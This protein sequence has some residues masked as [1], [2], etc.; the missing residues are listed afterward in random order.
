[1]ITAQALSNHPETPLHSDSLGERTAVPDPRTGELV[2]LLRVRPALTVIPS[3]EFALRERLA[4]LAN[5]RHPSFAV[6]RRVDRVPAPGLGIIVVSDHIAGTRLSELL[7]IAR[8]QRLDVD[9]STA[10]CLLRQIVPSIASLH[11]HVRGVAHGLVAPDRLVITPQ[12]RV[13]VVEHVFGAAIGQLQLS[14]KGLWDEFRATVPVDCEV[15]RFDPRADILSLGVVA[16][17]LVLG[18]PIAG[19]EFPAAL[20]A[21]LDQARERTALGYERPLSA[22]LR[23]WIERALQIHGS[24]SFATAAEAAGALEAIVADDSLYVTA[25]ISLEMFLARCAAAAIRPAMPLG[26]LRAT[27]PPRPAEAPVV[28]V[29]PAPPPAVERVQPEPIL[30][31][32]IAPDIT[33][34]MPPVAAAARMADE[35]AVP[36]ADDIDWDSVVG[37]QLTAVATSQDITSLFGEA[38]SLLE[39]AD[40]T[41]GD[42]LEAIPDRAEPPSILPHLPSMADSVR[43]LGAVSD[44]SALGSRLSS[45]RSSLSTLKA[46]GS[47][48]AT[49]VSSRHSAL[50]VRASA[51]GS[52]VDWSAVSRRFGIAALLVLIVGGGVIVARSLLTGVSADAS[53]GT[54]LV[55]SSPEGLHVLIDGVDQGRTPARLAVAPGTHTLEVRASGG[56]RIVPFTMVRGGKVSQHFEFE[57]PAPAPSGSAPGAIVPPSATAGATA[58]IPSSPAAVPVPGPAKVTARST[59]AV[60]TPRPPAPATGWLSIRAGFPLE[61]RAGGRV[62]GRNDVD[63]V[64][65]PAGRHEILL[66]NDDLGYR[67]GRVVQVAPG[68]VAT[69][70]VKAPQGS[71]NIN[72]VPWAEV[73]IDG[74]RIGETPLGNLP[75][76]VG[77]HV[78]VFRHPQLGE[79]RQSVSITLGAP[80]RVSVDMR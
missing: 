12:G 22:P 44:V 20:P 72:A 5:F 43:R 52:L 4:R 49:V 59:R 42:D 36:T 56:T 14:P 33:P 26:T 67:E 30:P 46:Q 13:V 66:V 31:P 3:F 15:A 79:K 48:S 61:I 40:A 16:L 21:L 64:R 10:L 34:P 70:A 74:Q 68:K 76:A 18:R 58:V 75:V 28:H 62:V 1:M 55:Q 69:V 54:L 7:R 35:A 53:N 65:M 73:W 32:Q 23:G 41:P 9:I 71:V 17:A 77:R 57:T 50:G 29:A 60:N 63:R 37:S 25:P 80:A 47:A 27:P 45:L 6:V 51:I 38:D 8:L 39:V 78:I 2:Q 11:A 19:D 24:A